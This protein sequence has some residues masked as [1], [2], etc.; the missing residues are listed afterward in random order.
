[1]WQLIPGASQPVEED[2]PGITHTEGHGVWQGDAAPDAGLPHG[3]QYSATA[4]PSKAPVPHI[5]GSDTT[6]GRI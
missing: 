1:M 6:F 5:L 3:F 2:D 4:A